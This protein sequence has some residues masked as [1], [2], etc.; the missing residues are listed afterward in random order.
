MPCSCAATDCSFNRVSTLRSVGLTART[1][2]DLQREI[3]TGDRRAGPGAAGARGAGLPHQRGDDS[4]ALVVNLEACVSF[5]GW[6]N[7]DAFLMED[8]VRRID[9][10]L[11]QQSVV[12]TRP[13]E[14]RRESGE[15]RRGR[16]PRP[17]VLPK[18]PR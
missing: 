1:V 16:E 7:S 9:E 3:G 14:A 17:K 11:T 10:W 18:G 8:E 15:S 6:R 2:A 13:R 4:S 12:R 5:V